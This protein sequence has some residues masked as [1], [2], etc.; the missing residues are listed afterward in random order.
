MKF[1]YDTRKSDRN[2][3]KHGI[4][5]DDAQEL[6]D[7]PDLL[8]IPARTEDEPRFMVI[9]RIRKAH[10]SGII[11]YRKGAIRI[12]SVRRSRDEEVILYEG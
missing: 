11:T 4:N 2:A 5:F 8:E 1:Q 3:E 7:D 9:G 12:I 10:W 6:W